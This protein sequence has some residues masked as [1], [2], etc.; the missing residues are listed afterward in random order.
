MVLQHPEFR[1]PPPLAGATAPLSKEVDKEVSLLCP[2][3]KSMLLR[4]PQNKNQIMSPITTDPDY[5]NQTLDSIEEEHGAG[6]PDPGDDQD[7]DLAELAMFTVTARKSMT[8]GRK[9]SGQ[10]K[11]GVLA[12]SHL[13]S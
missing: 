10:P 3:A 6:Q 2:V 13:R 8:L 1:G 11:G 9:F 4:L 7:M 12:R 5:E